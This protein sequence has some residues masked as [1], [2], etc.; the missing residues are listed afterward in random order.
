MRDQDASEYVNIPGSK[1]DV[2]GS[3]A[4]QVVCYLIT[5]ESSI[6]STPALGSFANTGEMG[7]ISEA[8]I[9]WNSSSSWLEA[10]TFLGFFAEALA[11][12]VEWD[13]RF[14]RE[15]VDDIDID[16]RAET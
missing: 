9:T 8:L 12:S 14:L 3:K 6:S 10:N 16:I 15:V 7:K 2:V 13:L 4:L 11:S 1:N 5:I